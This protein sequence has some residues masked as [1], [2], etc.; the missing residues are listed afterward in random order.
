VEVEYKEPSMISGTD[1]AIWSETN[2]EHID[3]H[4]SRSSPVLHVCTIAIA[5]AIFLN[6]CWKLYSEGVQH[7]LR[8]CLKSPQLCQ[9]G[10]LLVL[11]SIEET[12]KRRVGHVVF[13][14]QFSGEKVSL[15]RCVVMMQQSVLLLA[16]LGAKSSHIFM[17]SP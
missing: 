4:H 14:Q 8:F 15:R 11:S 10:G 17:Q 5:S 3:H 12:E 13:G 9:N 1:S 2:F 6:A 7:G 16:K